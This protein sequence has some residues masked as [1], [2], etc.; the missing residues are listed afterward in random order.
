MIENKEKKLIFTLENSLKDFQ[1]KG[2]LDF[3]LDYYNP[4]GYFKK[5]YFISYNPDDREIEHN[6]EWL[7]V[8]S[9]AYFSFLKSIKRF[10]VLFLLAL[11][12]VFFIHFFNLLYLIK[13][14]KVDISRTGHPY[15][16]SLPLWLASKIMR[17]P[18]VSTLGGDNRLAQEKI[19]RYH[20]FN[21]KFLSFFV[22]E[23]LVGK[24]DYVI[25]PNKYTANYAQRISRQENLAVIP[26]PLRNEIFQNLEKDSKV[27]DPKYFLFIGRF[28]G[29]KHPDFV[30]E[31]YISY[32]KNHPDSP[33]DLV[34]IGDGEIKEQLIQRAKEAGISS[35]VTFTGFLNT[36]G[37]TS[38]LEENPI[39]LIPISGFV[40]YEAAIFGNMIVT[41]DIEWHSEFV[42]DNK[43]GWVGKYLDMDDWLKKL[44]I[45]DKD[46]TLAKAKALRLREKM[47]I[48]EP[49]NIYS[50]QVEVYTKVLNEK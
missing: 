47:R 31:L 24:S 22:E 27:D 33:L 39:C 48:L 18:F 29:D 2:N 10:K 25:V 4:N 44:S 19:G 36:K 28:V 3:A 50:K 23:L 45:I 1:E 40:I 42:E 41:S 12:F 8:F 26:L 9:P 7:E 34:M 46:F 35:R 32:L 30:L 38:Y 43:T 49:R 37:I 16:M 5:V 20:I 11:P 15:L 17:I 21:N 13:K 6:K 14:E